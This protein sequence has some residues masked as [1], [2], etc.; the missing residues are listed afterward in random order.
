ME[1][2]S[3]SA[4]CAPTIVSPTHSPSSTILPSIGAT[5]TNLPPAP[6]PASASHA[7]TRHVFIISFQILSVLFS[8]E[9][10]NEF[11]KWNEKWVLEGS[12]ILR[13]SIS[14]WTKFSDAPARPPPPKNIPL[15]PKSTSP[16]S[17]AYAVVR[18][19]VP[20]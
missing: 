18:I 11:D 19:Y 17:E 15:S 20:T 16:T 8:F 2:T 9:I 6:G 12:S 3:I 7:T 1:P 13:L 4:S 5:S 10:G 14:D